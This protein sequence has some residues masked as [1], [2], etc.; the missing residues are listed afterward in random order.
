M[1]RRY[2]ILLVGYCLLVGTIFSCSNP[3]NKAITLDDP[4]NIVLVLVDDLGWKDLHLYGS[5]YYQTPSIDRL[6]NRGMTFS[7][8]YACAANCAPS[9]ASLLCG[10]YTPRH[11]IYTVGS[12]ER[13]NV[14][15]RKLIPTPNNT[16]LCDSI[17]T[18]A[19]ELKNTGYV[20]ASIGKW[21]LGDNPCLQGFDVNIGGTHLGHP[22]S[23][24]SP[25]RNK[26][27]KDGKEGEYLTD[28]LTDEA[29]KFI[30]NNQKNKFLL[31][32]PYYSVHTPLEGK[33]TLVEKYDTITGSNG[34]NNAVYAA[35]VEV[36]DENIG[37]I[38]AAL[39][40]LQLSEKTLFII[41]SDNGGVANLSS[42]YP[43]K[44]GK[45]SYYEGGIRVPLIVSM[46]GVVQQKSTCNVPVSH[47][48]LYPS[49]L[50]A[51]GIESP[52]SDKLDGRNL[53]PLFKGDKNIDLNRPLFWH[54]PIYL[55][56]YKLDF[57]DGRDQ[58]F[59][60]R[61]GSVIRFGKWKLHEYFEDGS[62][63]LY[64]L[65]EDISEQENL[66]EK[67]PEIVFQLY[68]TLLEWREEVR[69]PVRN[70]LNPYYHEQTN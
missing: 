36:V 69:A 35:M 58:F 10:L 47:I 64:N 37:R 38:M 51:A 60:T 8:A 59:R 41:T 1:N 29:I 43:L 67:Y 24:F 42:Q 5:S 23:Y 53:I 13:G 49:L 27:L 55:Q 17:V 21:H 12:S 70:Q 9:R 63:E 22:K 25:Y 18:I 44:Y 66:V 57:M 46:P 68:Q 3:R 61:P 52:L 7:N 50:E 20:T 11:G 6:A 39:D 30:K 45:G 16:F 65:E 31:Y 56:S 40:S 48:D 32:L 19:E 28:R 4:P 2:L 34:Q 15:H 26:A 14:K 54:F 33:K 62:I